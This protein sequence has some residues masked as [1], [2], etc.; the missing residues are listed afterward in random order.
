MDYIS[1]ENDARWMRRRIVELAHKA[2]KR[3]AHLGGSLSAV[4]ILCAVYA[5]MTC[6]Q[7]DKRDRLI[8]SKG[9]A[10]LALYALLE[11][12]AVL[13]KE[14]TDTFEENGTLYYAHVHSNPQK[15]FEFSGGSLSLGLSFAHGV[16]LACK[17]KNYGNRIFVVIGDG[18]CDEGLIWESLMSIS[19]DKLNNITIIVDCNG[20]QLDGATKDVM[21]SNNLAQK[22]ESF[23]FSTFEV[24]GHD[25]AQL[26]ETMKEYSENKPVAIIAKTTKGKGLSFCEGQSLWH[27]NV[28]T[29]KLYTQALEELG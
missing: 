23:G 12:N 27:H 17:A 21:D 20:I 18:E 9:H 3:G 25:F 24:N 1:L 13:T 14:E 4:E 8:L 26:M 16:A 6:R 19:N 11:R 22:I 2:G 7:G 28:L 10:A 29:D 5:T 15:G